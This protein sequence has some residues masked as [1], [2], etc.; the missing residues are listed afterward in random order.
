MNRDIELLFE[1]GALRNMPRQ[2]S[3]FHMPNVANNSEHM[4]RVAWIALVIAAREGTKV[5]TEKIIKMALAHDIA[6]SRT[7][8]V[9][10]IARQYVQRDE[11]KAL[12]DMLEDTSLEAEFTELLSEYEARETLEAKIV[13]DADTL[14]VDLELREQHSQGHTLPSS[15]GKQRNYVGASKLFTKAARAMHATIIASDSNDWHIKSPHNRLN[16]GDWKEKQ[17]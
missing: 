5:D 15:W 6:E 14:D 9:D 10:Y 4:F 2:W 7:G 13:K 16:G 17:S 11:P 1:L 8:D 3:R 12:H